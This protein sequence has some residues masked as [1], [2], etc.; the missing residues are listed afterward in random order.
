MEVYVIQ[1]GVGA[2][3]VGPVQ[4]IAENGLA[5]PAEGLRFVS[6]N[7]QPERITVQL[8]DS[9]ESGIVSSVHKARR[10][11]PVGIRPSR[12]VRMTTTDVS[13]GRAYEWPKRTGRQSAKAV[14]DFAIGC[15][16]KK[17]EGAAEQFRHPLR[18]GRSEPGLR[19]VYFLTHSRVRIDRVKGRIGVAVWRRRQLEPVP[20]SFLSNPVDTNRTPPKDDPGNWKE[21]P[22]KSILY[23]KDAR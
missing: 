8:E 2:R 3:E 19:S 6:A 1:G 7:A 9:A 5:S 12:G 18:A 21:L 10:I 13:T 17:R 16:D 15:G 4:Y 14:T 11:A 22:L 23:G 20:R